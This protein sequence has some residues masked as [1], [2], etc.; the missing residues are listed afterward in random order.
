MQPKAHSFYIA[1]YLKHHTK[2]YLNAFGFAIGDY[3]PSELSGLPAVDINHIECRGM[4]G[5]PTGGKDRIENL[6]AVTREEHVKYGDKKQ[7]KVLLYKKHMEYLTKKQVRF[8]RKYMLS[9]IKE[10]EASMEMDS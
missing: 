7:H 3:I 2:V 4:G 10:H 5:D 6:M 9:K 8:D 1:Q